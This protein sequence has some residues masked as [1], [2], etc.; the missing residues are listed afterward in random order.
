[1]KK[2]FSL[3]FKSLLIDQTKQFFGYYLLAIIALFFT[4]KIQSD[5]PFLAKNL[6]DKI[7][8]E[9]ASIHMSSFFYLALGIIFFRTTSRILFFYPARLLQKMLRTEM[10]LKLENTSPFRYRHINSGQIFQYLNGDIDQIRALIGFVGLQGGNLII[11]LLVLVPRLFAFHPQLVYALTPMVVSFLLFTYFVSKSSVYF[12]KIQET[13]GEVQ[14]LIIESYAGKKTIKNFHSEKSF[15]SLFQELSLLELYYFY[16][17]SLGISI[18]L[19]FV[20]FGV[21]LSLLCWQHAGWSVACLL[22]SRLPLMVG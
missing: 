1:M 8:T 22:A 3:S 13:N 18:F 20:T 7:S 4:H 5:L 17:A 2:Y 21:G 6:A 15:Y 12:K 10:I 19:P 16:R 11:G 14:N 9:P